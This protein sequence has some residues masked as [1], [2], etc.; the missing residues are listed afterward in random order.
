M[1]TAT[2]WFYHFTPNLII[3]TNLQKLDITWIFQNQTM[4]VSV[5]VEVNGGLF[6]HLD[7]FME[8]LPLV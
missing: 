6:R 8:N 5:P 2:N 4:G 3:L 1:L 7:Y